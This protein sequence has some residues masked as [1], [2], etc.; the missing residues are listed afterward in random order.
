[1]NIAILTSNQPR[2]AAFINVLR[3]KINPKMIVIEE[4]M[5][6]DFYSSEE[7][8]FSSIN[9]GKTFESVSVEKGKINTKNIRDKISDANIDMCLVFGTSLLKS[10]TIN[11][12]KYGCLNIHTGLVQGYRGVDSPWWAI[13]NSEPEMIGIT[14]HQVTAGI[15]DGKVILQARTK[16]SKEDTIE[17]IFFKTC[18]LGFDCLADNIEKIMNFDYESTSV[19]K[20]N[21]Y[22]HKNMSEEIKMSIDANIHSIISHYLDNENKIN[23]EKNKTYGDFKWKL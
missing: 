14:I 1:M 9:T 16:L 6:S 21:L 18:K 8:F 17:S 10:E 20:G 19:T 3:R 5:K 12:P 23:L 4:K 11:I 13:Y 15:D 7:T 22:Q 2:H